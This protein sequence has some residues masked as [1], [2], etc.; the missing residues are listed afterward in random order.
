LLHAGLPIH[1]PQSRRG[2]HDSEGR[3][4]RW[5]R[6]GAYAGSGAAPAWPDDRVHLD[7]FGPSNREANY[8]DFMT[9]GIDIATTEFYADLGW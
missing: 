3:S 7:L 6:A 4:W 9:E 8:R 2:A 5:S 1:P